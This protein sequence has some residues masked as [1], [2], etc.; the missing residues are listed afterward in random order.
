MSIYKLRAAGTGGTQNDVASLDVQFDGI[1]QGLFGSLIAD[2][3]ADLEY[4]QVEASFLS[5]NT[6]GSNDSRGSLIIISTQIQAVTA[7]SVVPGSVN[8]GIGGLEVP[9]SAGERLHL[10]IDASAGVTSVAQLYIYTRDSGDP[11]L[12][13]RR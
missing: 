1:I 4:C 6:I 7:A 11:R 3:D 8:G 12:R 9:I 10:H 2:L 5:T 13:R